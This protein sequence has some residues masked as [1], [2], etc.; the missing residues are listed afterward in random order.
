MAENPPRLS[1]SVVVRSLRRLRDR[2]FPNSS[3]IAPVLEAGDEEATPGFLEN[4]PVDVQFLVMTYLSIADLCRLG[5]TSH[6]WRGIVRD[7]LLWKFFLLRDIPYWDSIDYL[8]MP[9]LELL[10]APL[11][12]KHESLDEREEG[13]DKGNESKV[14][15]MAEYLRGSPSCRQQWLP[16]LAPY[17]TVTSFLQSLVASVEPRYAMFGPGMEQLDVSFVTRLMHAPDVLPVS[18]TPHRQIN[19]IGSGIS[20]LF[21]NQHKFNILT[22]YST[23][24]AE[25]ERARAQQQSVTN[26]LFTVEGSDE[27]GAPIYSPAPQVQQVCQVV[28]GFIYVANAERDDSEFEAAQIGTLLSSAWGSTSRPLLV[29]SCV[30]SE[31]REIVTDSG[32]HPITKRIPSVYMA[33]RLELTKLANP[34][35]VQDVVAESLSGLLDGISWLLRCSGVKLHSR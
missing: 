22:L 8:S 25:R 31:E 11:I 18:G 28:D 15:Y 24:K 5:A 29:L 14:D 13:A 32:V 9:Q 17:K 4:L 7:P 10:D 27:S 20:Y 23:N 1:E 6:Y 33:K 26:K 19:G 34:W 21:N 30:S 2:Y 12:D 35:M 3:V 16:S